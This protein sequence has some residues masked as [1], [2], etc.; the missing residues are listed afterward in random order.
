MPSTYHHSPVLNPFTSRIIRLWLFV[1]ALTLTGCSPFVSYQKDTALSEAR[2]LTEMQSNSGIIEWWHVLQDTRLNQQIESALKNNGS[3]QATFERITAAYATAAVNDANRSPQIS[4][5]ASASHR[6]EGSD[7]FSVGLSVS[8]DPDLWKRLSMLDDSAQFRV[9]S[10]VESY[11]MAALSLSVGIATTWMKIIDAQQQLTLLKRQIINAQQT[12]ELMKLRYQAGLVRMEDILRQQLS[13]QSL[14]AE[15]ITINADIAILNSQLAVLTGVPPE[16]T[17]VVSPNL[18]AYPA[19]TTVDTTWLHRRPDIREA[20][21]SM[22]ATDRD[23]A[24]AVRNQYP[25]LTLSVSSVSQADSPRALFSDW[26][27]SLAANFAMPLIDGGKRRAQAQQA[28][29]KRAE[30]VALYQQKVL[31]ALDEVQAAL[32]KE[33]QQ[34]QAIENLQQRF[35][36]AKT[37]YE[38]V[39]QSYFSGTGNYLSVLSAQKERNAL[40]RNLLN[41]QRSLIELR[42]NL[43]QVVAGNLQSN[44]PDKSL[45]MSSKRIQP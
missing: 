32:I 41:A 1:A 7:Q 35:E 2:R 38:Q 26:I 18:P 29:A 6:I 19:E 14:Q 5:T 43:H 28:K 4:T 25:A 21:Y 36:L 13:E 8:Y 40:E 11:R 24:A 23:F 31:Q 3:V 30:F 10:S 16:T 15:E 39:E 34:R 12:H 44:T 20:F 37:V 33:K 22:S 45:V 9:Q 17:I 27:T 42:I